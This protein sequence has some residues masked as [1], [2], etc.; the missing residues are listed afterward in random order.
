MTRYV[1]GCDIGGTFTDIVLR[2]DGAV[3]TLKLPSTP[4]DYSRAILSA[5]REIKDRFGIDAQSIDAVYERKYKW[6]LVD[7]F[8]EGAPVAG[9]EHVTAIELPAFLKHPPLQVYRVAP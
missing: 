2:G 3:R 9:F 8:A 6:F 1:L 7:P 4:D 5:V